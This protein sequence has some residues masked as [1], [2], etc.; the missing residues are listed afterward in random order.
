MSRQHRT[1]LSDE[2]LAAK[3][4]V[5]EDLVRD[6]VPIRHALQSAGI[7]RTTYYRHRQKIGGDRLPAIERD[8]RASAESW[9]PPN[10]LG[11]S[12]HS[13]QALRREIPD[14]LRRCL[15]RSVIARSRDPR[16]EL[17][18]FVEAFAS[19]CEAYEALDE[20]A[21][22]HLEEMHEPDA[23]RRTFSSL[24]ESCTA[25]APDL[26]ACIEAFDE[27][28]KEMK[29][30]GGGPARD[31]RILS[32]VQGLAELFVRH[33]S[34]APTHTIAPGDGFP[35][36]PFNRFVEDVRRHFLRE[37]DVT[38]A[39]FTDTA[40]AD[41]MQDVAARLDWSEDLENRD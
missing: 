23:L 2:V 33:F 12:E 5:V 8:W 39:A 34:E 21:R 6:G 36:S 19:A 29:E 31:P 40:F 22:V 11:L 15:G 4:L 38:D 10:G 35:A 26:K 30:T 13:F 20:E 9:P 18:R 25:F 37:V 14:V 1:R 16:A 27:H 24:F 3:T 32:L 7:S 17:R 41:A 28:A